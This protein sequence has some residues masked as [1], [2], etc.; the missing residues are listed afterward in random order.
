LDCPKCGVHNRKDAERCRMCGNPM[1]Q[2]PREIVGP[3]KVCPFCHTVN[4][5]D[6]PFCSDCGKPMGAVVIDAGEERRKRERESARIYT[7]YATGPVRTARLGTA[8]I[9]LLMVVAFVAVD[10]ALTFFILWD[11]STTSDYQE[12]VASNSLYATAFANLMACQVIRLIFLALTAMGAMAAMRKLNFG[13]AIA[14]AVFGVF[15]LGTS[16]FALVSGFWLLIT[17]A[18]FIGNLVA[19]GFI[20]ASRREFSIA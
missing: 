12:L 18:L 5:K 15:A 6:A 20:I 4:E 16:V 17:S 19:L 8:G 1:R 11:F 9:I 13:L 10:M 3:T 7:D 2:P 14:G